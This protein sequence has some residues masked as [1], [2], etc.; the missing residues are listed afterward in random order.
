MRDYLA[1]GALGV[2]RGRG[3]FLAAG[4]WR[5][6]AALLTAGFYLMVAVWVCSCSETQQPLEWDQSSRGGLGEAPDTVLTD[7]VVVANAGY[8]VAVVTGFSS[9]FMVGRI[10][11]SGPAGDQI[12]AQAY[13]RWDVSE[14]PEGQVQSAKLDL[15]LRNV[16]EADSP[17]PGL[18]QLRMYEVADTTWEEEDLGPLPPIAYNTDRVWYSSPIDV[19]GVSDTS[20]V[21]L[22]D[23][24]DM[25]DLVEEWHSDHSSNHGVVIVPLATESKG[26]LRFISREGVPEGY[27]TEL[28]TPALAVEIRTADGDSTTTLEPES[29]GYVMFGQTAV[30]A[31]A[32]GFVA[33]ETDTAMLLSSGYVQR[34]VMR[35]DLAVLAAS[36]P[37]RFPPGIAV[38]QATLH[39]TPILNEDWSLDPEQ[40]VTI[41]VYETDTEWSE[42]A[43]PEQIEASGEVVSTVIVTGS[44]TTVVLDIREA[45]QMALGAEDAQ[46]NLMIRCGSEADLFRSLLS[47]TRRAV[48]GRPRMRMVFTRP[49][50]GRFTP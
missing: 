21:A 4:L 14:L 8:S 7:T 24:F 2:P 12:T 20:D 33:G 1:P 10:V 39:L 31:R 41:R 40:D 36:D 26:F 29:D 50:P 9:Y 48:V 25:T 22:N 5:K 18:F 45:V 37:Q 44:D 19:S 23:V 11:R 43:M 6:R 16:E 46:L 28:G 32:G 38:H 42:D 13:L 3:S 35:L 49:G 27:P 15:V 17:E 30:L 47:K 34:L